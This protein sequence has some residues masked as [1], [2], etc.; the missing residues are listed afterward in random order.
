MTNEE[1]AA[2]IA[3]MIEERRGT[4]ARGMDDRTAAIDAELARV[5]HEGATPAK[6]AAKRPAATTRTAAKR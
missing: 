3:A 4:V 2:Y 1:R 5:G 6:R